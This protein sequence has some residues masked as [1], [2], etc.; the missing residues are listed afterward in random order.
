VVLADA[1]MTKYLSVDPGQPVYFIAQEIFGTD[2]VRPI[3]YSEF[4]ICSDVLCLH[5]ETI[6]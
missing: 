1:G 3:S 4:Y 2:V 5:G 6:L